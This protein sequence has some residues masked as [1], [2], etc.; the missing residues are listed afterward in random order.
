MKK[1][2]MNWPDF[3]TLEHRLIA[4]NTP[5]S[6]AYIHGMMVGLL[7]VASGVPQ[8]SWLRIQTEMP[9][10][11][12][13]ATTGELF[14]SLFLLTLK[15]LQDVNKVVLLMLPGEDLPLSYRLEALSSW[16]EGFLEGFALEHLS[17][18]KLA[19]LP[20]VEEVLLDFEHIKEIAFDVNETEENEK[21]FT[22]IIEFIRVGVLLVHAECKQEKI[23]HQLLH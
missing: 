14:N 21:D 23:S 2:D 16:C 20:L 18:E 17:K 13:Q 9:A 3:D 8:S 1:H 7:C 4:A 12:E 10:I 15:Q 22:E 5:F 6:P 11:A 19:S